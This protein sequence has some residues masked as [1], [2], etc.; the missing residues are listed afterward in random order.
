MS[1]YGRF[2]E[3]GREYIV[4]EPATPRQF[5]NFLWNESMFSNVAQTGAG[6]FDYQ[7]A[8]TEAVQLLTGNGRV[9]DF[10]VFGRESLLSRLFYV[11]DNET[12]AFWN[13]NWEPVCAAYDK[14]TCTHGL[15]YTVIESQTSGI[16]GKLSVFVP[17]G[18]DA[19]ELWK[20]TVANNSGKRRDLSLFSY[21][22]F[23]FRYKW[24]FDSYG[25]MLY[26][27]SDFYPEYNAVVADKHPHVRP[28]D[29]LKGYLTADCPVAAWDGSRDAFVGLYGSLSA[30]KAVREG[31]CSNTPGS[32]DA[33]VGAAQFDL[34]LEAGEEKTIC[35][36]LGASDSL[37]GIRAMREKY[38]GNFDKYFAEL[39]AAKER[40]LSVHQ[41][42]TPDGCFDNMFN[43]WMKEQSLFGAAWCRW[44]WMGYRDIV[45]HG[46]GVVSMEPERAKEIL[47][48]AM[49]YQYASGLAVRGWN[50]VDTKPYSDC[51]LW[52]CFTLAAY[53]RETGDIGLLRESIPFFD[54][55]E[56]DIL[57]HVET[58]LRFLEEHKGSHGLCLIKFGDWNDSLTAVGK[59]GRGESVWL[60]LAY[61]EALRDI[62]G[63]YGFLGDSGKKSD[64]ETRRENILSAINSNAWDGQWYLRCFDDFGGKIGSSENEEGSIF[65]E[66][67]AWALISGAA[68]GEKAGQVVDS[69]DKLLQTSQGYK[70]L[71]PTFTQVD[72]RIGRLSSL[73][74]GI[75]EN[76]TIYTHC[77]VWM[78]LGM[79]RSGM[80][81]RAYEQFRRISAIYHT[82]EDHKDK[83]PPYIYANC[84]YGPDHRNN[85]YQMEFTWITGSIS[86]LN[87]VM[88]ENF[89]GV[90]ADYN[91]LVIAPNVPAE[92]GNYTY[93]RKFRRA[94]YEIS[95]RKQE[96]KECGGVR[97][98]VDGKMIEGNTAP[99]FGDGLIHRVDA[100]IL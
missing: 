72:E 64:A 58:A 98:R 26:R 89:L 1:G 56:T 13:V 39:K 43:A 18:R 6:Y 7:F 11:R 87:R 71:A 86:W 52:L 77:N 62:A 41:V 74:P 92:W 44:G 81:G 78:I 17:D 75:C 49:R 28:H 94:D 36:I 3:D 10:D 40:L 100:E 19:V 32:S 45:Q 88:A 30:P 21:N 54:N 57:G 80:A 48:E 85:A 60:S 61:A 16:A 47:K 27:S 5:D 15:G 67:Q 22:Q 14:Y 91:G 96:G 66:P 59:E 76:G 12:A 46:M 31:R 90:A 69:C 8:D 2:S 93:K 73:E 82:P 20:L 83:C 29:Y 38:L 50:P 37:D 95:F 24:G 34:R 35:L 25:D 99:V 97:L 42:Q 4:T 23:Q 55:G 9:C 70:L 33:T 53:V 63:L 68:D 51:A 65:I 79:L 84:Y